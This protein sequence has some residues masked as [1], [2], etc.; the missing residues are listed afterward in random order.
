MKKNVMFVFIVMAVSFSILACEVTIPIGDGSSR[1]VRGSG[2]LDEEERPVSDFTEVELAMQGILNIELGER[3]S[4]RIEAE[5]NLL[6]HIETQV[7]AGR[8]TIDSERGVTLRNSMPI[9][10][11]LTVTELDTLVISSSGDILAPDLEAEHFSVNISSSG[12]L[13]MGDLICDS[14]N[15]NISSSGDLMMGDLQADTLDVRLSSSGGLSIAGG[16]V[17]RQ[18]ISISSSGEY[19]AKNLESAEARVRISS[20]GAVTIWVR[21]DLEADI[22]SSGDVF[23]I[24]DPEVDTTTS[25]SGDVIQIRE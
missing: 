18:E 13:S 1:T 15:A 4:L 20:S 9:R 17:Q 16:S 2:T 8:L 7:R 21:D 22:S 25:S 14:F 11:Q 24:G 12:D 19:I 5:D 10:Y 6:E 23:Y 3:V